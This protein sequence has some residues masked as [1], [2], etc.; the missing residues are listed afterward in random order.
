MTSPPNPTNK[1]EQMS[2]TKKAR[3]NERMLNVPLK[4]EVRE[5]LDERACDN[6]RPTRREA[7]RIIEDAVM[8]VR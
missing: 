8:G 3:K 1:E 7:A 6:G 4:P 2:K 5:R